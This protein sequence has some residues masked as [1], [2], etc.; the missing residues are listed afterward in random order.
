MVWSGDNEVH[1]YGSISW[2]K[3]K[4]KTTIVSKINSMS[5][6]EGDL[7]IKELRS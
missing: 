3:L 1:R 5:F 6:F 2:I 7:L 4:L